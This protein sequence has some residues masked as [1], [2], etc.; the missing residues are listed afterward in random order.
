MSRMLKQDGFIHLTQDA[1]YLLSIGNLFYKAVPGAFVL[2]CLDPSKLKA[3]VGP[4][5]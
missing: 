3:K 1:S 2:L 4:S 5:C